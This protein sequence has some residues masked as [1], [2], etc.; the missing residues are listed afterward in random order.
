MILGKKRMNNNK[1]I[2]NKKPSV[3]GNIDIAART[4]GG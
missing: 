4:E 2:E 1:Q 3:S